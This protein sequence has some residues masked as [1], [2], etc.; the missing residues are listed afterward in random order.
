MDI[1]ASGTHIEVSAVVI[2][3]IED[4]QIVE[5]WE[6]YDNL[7]FMQ[8]TRRDPRRDGSLAARSFGLEAAS[9]A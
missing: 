7:E 6:I 8:Q 9:A 4:D 2:A 5:G 3:R 1:P